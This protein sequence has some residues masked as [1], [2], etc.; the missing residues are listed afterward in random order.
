MSDSIKENDDVMEA[1]GSF[2]NR[3]LPKE[4]TIYDHHNRFCFTGYYH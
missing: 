4:D 1:N 3:D 2:D